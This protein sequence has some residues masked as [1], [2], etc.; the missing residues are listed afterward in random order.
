[1]PYSPHDDCVTI[2]SRTIARVPIIQAKTT[3]LAIKYPE[4]LEPSASLYC[5]SSNWLAGD[6]HSGQSEEDRDGRC[7][8]SDKRQEID[9]WVVV[10][11]WGM[12]CEREV[13]IVAVGIGCSFWIPTT[14]PAQS[15]RAD[16]Q[17]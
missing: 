13:N 15:S 7:V 17:K 4:A 2:H 10:I 11:G 5:K 6:H 9:H 12:S 16:R 8:C 3:E 14:I 1:M